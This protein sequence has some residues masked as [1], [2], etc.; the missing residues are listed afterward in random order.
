VGI[1]ILILFDFCS[2]PIQFCH[3][4]VYIL[5]A[6]SRALIVLLYALWKFSSDAENLV[7]Q[8]LLF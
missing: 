1:P 5:E 7:L 6:E 3:M 4:I 8:A 2:F